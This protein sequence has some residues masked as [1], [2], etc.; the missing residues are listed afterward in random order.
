LARRP[1]GEQTAAKVLET[2]GPKWT[3]LHDVPVGDRGA[4]IDHVVIGPPGVFTINSKWHVGKTVWVGGNTLLIG[5]HRQPYV[6]K[7]RHEAERASRL[8]SRAYGSSVP[9]TGVVAVLAQSWTIR[10]QPRD[11]SVLVLWPSLAVE[12]LRSLPV[13][14]ATTDVDRLSWCARRSANWRQ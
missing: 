8:L 4:N 1:E 13:R 2:L 7:G 14:Y 10:E 9:V 11:E 12:L 6:P 5:R 3:T